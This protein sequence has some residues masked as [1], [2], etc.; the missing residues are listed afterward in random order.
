MLLTADQHKRLAEV[1]EEA[2]A[3]QSQKPE[4]RT[5]LAR[6]AARFRR[7]AR[8]REDQSTAVELRASR[9]CLSPMQRVWP[10]GAAC[11]VSVK[12]RLK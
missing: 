7:L 5:L 8:G 4:D 11:K 1:F 9:F 6:K 10:H 3:D 2:A 12:N